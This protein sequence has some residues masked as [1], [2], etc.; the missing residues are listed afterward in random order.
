METKSPSKQI[1]LTPGTNE[2]KKFLLKKADLSPS[3]RKTAK[4]SSTGIK[5]LSQQNPIEVL[6]PEV[7]ISN[8]EVNQTYEVAVLVR[9]LTNQA[10]RIRIFQPKTTKFRCD[11]E[12]PGAIAAGLAMKLAVTFET[13]TLNDYHD[14]LKIISDGGFE[15]I[16]PLHAFMPQANLIFDPFVNFGFVQ[17]FKEKTETIWFYNEGKKDGVVELNQPEKLGEIRLEKSKII[18]SPGEKVPVKVTYQ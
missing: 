8:I 5:Y 14:E 12:M 13:S 15:L 6:P 11:Y 16:V 7:I 10:R 1:H 17:L 4:E 2:S 18:V 9:N 3:S